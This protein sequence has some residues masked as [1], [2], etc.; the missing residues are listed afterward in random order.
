[1][2]TTIDDLRKLPV[3]A[4]IAIVEE[5]WDSI[6]ADSSNLPLTAAQIAEL[7]RRLA[8]HDAARDEGESWPAL[9][10]RLK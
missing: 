7:D 9:R 10:N 6:S 8:A 3:A 1:M 5:L 2:T 4:R